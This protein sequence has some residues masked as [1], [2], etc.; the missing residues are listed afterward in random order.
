MILPDNKDLAF[1]NGLGMLLL[2]AALGAIAFVLH[3]LEASSMAVCLTCLV[4]FLVVSLLL[5]RFGRG[6]GSSD[7]F[8]A[9]WRRMFLFVVV[10]FFVGLI[11]EFT[12]LHDTTTPVH[13]MNRTVSPYYTSTHLKK[14]K[15]G[16]AAGHW[17]ATSR[18]MTG[19]TSNAAF[20]T[21]EDWLWDESAASCKF[22]HLTPAEASAHFAGKR[23]VF[24]GDSA[25]RHTYHQFNHMLD[26]AG[27]YHDDN[28][29]KYH[30]NMGFVH[31]KGNVTVDFVWAP[32]VRNITVSLQEPGNSNGDFYVLGASLWDAL[33]VRDLH[34]YLADLE[35]LARVLEET[36]GALRKKT[37]WLPSLPVLDDKLTTG[38]KQKYMQEATAETYRQA[39][40]TSSMREAVLT[41]VNPVNITRGREDS[42]ADGVHYSP[43]VYGVLA[44]LVGNL[45][46]I[47]HRD[48]PVHLLSQPAKNPYPHGKPTGSMSSPVYGAI[49]LGVAA[50]ML[51]GWD[52]FLG[53]GLLSLKL[54]GRSANWNDAYLPILN[55][56]MPSVKTDEDAEEKSGLLEMKVHDTE[57]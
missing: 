26:V 40:R 3:Q 15:N 33:H 4:L 35:A 51:F 46:V 48:L 5:K 22:H 2:L 54:F 43:D 38:D 49:V 19:K 53:V 25:I 7:A 18:C 12:I 30:A 55:K 52:S 16:L 17:E 50:I 44:Q 24:V 28:A 20:C 36:G 47:T 11:A 8:N 23:I 27:V 32:F 21:T 56:I 57:A 13:D 31:T 10:L 39:F 37:V 6:I 9:V 14:C 41:A 29:V 45:Y 34:S 42:S 1:R